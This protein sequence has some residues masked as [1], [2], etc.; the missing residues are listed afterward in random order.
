MADAALTPEERDALAAELSLGVLEGEERAAAFRSLLADPGFTPEVID[1]W[2]RRLAPLYDAYVPVVPP[3]MLWSGIEGRIADRLQSHPA[4]RQLRWWRAGALAS[5]AVAASLALVIVLRPTPPLAYRPPVQVAVAQMVG[6]PDGPTILARYDPA[7]GG[8]KLRSTG[9]ESGSLAPEL[10]VIPAD[11]KPR[12]LGLIASG[13]ESRLAVSPSYRRFMT[14]GATL[15]VT[16]EAVTGAPHQA[17]SSAPIAAG[18]ISL[19]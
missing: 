1:A 5:A 4:A 15:A 14:E 18:K 17:P 3:E 10:W 8:L 2:E 11:G 7:S 12:S 6:A 19:L 13:A 9:M 16:M